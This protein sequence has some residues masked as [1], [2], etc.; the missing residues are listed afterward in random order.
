M[1]NDKKDDMFLSRWITGALTEEEQKA[2][3]Q[4]PDYPE[5]LKLK[6]SSDALEIKEYDT[7]A[8]LESLKASRAKTPSNV[9][10][11]WTY[12]AVAA[13]IVIIFGLFLFPSSATFS[14]SYGEQIVVALPD[15]SEMILNAKSKASFDKKNW[16]TNRSIA[17]QGEAYFK[18]KKGKTFTVK[19]D[20]GSVT[21]LG[22]QF[23]INTQTNYFE[24]ICYEGKVR[25]ASHN[26]TSILTAG[27]AFRKIANTPKESWTLTAT[28]PSWIDQVSS[29]KNVPVA[30]VIKELEEQYDITIQTTNIDQELIYTGTFPNTDITVALKTV[31]NTLGYNYSVSDDGKSVSLSK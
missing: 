5:Y 8:A 3:E 9:I 6:A 23:N 29:F 1:W 16:T 21:V 24:A 2:F 14:T 17:L 20:N 10:R 19:T 15:G 4:H 25:V 11:L 22:T 26:D 7:E 18:V 30:I 12:I 27:K 28:K 13:S 31:F